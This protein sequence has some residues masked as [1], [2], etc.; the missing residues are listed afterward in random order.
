MNQVEPEKLAPGLILAKSIF[1]SNGKLLYPCG[2]VLT[3]PRITQLKKLNRPFFWLHYPNSQPFISDDLIFQQITFQKN[4]KTGSGHEEHSPNANNESGVKA[5]LHKLLYE[6]K[7]EGK[8]LAAYGAAAKGAVLLNYC[9]IGKEFLDFV[10]DRS[11]CKQGRFM[12][13]VHLPLYAPSKLLEAM[14]DYV[15]LL[16]WNFADEILAQQ[17]EF[18]QRGGRF[19]IPIPETRT[20]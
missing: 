19:I 2:Y 18:R 13:G 12:P 8:R 17:A 14:P 1:K 20:V 16:A 5:S 15:L 4:L 10:V 3:A 7:Q 9:G 6:L 11:P